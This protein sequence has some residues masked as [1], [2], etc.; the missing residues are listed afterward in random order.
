MRKEEAAL[1]RLEKLCWWVL[2]E[3]GRSGGLA[4]N[5]ERAE[6]EAREAEK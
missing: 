2:A 4:L 1:S 6:E 3:E 5:D